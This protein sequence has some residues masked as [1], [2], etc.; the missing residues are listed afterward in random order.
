MPP[1]LSLDDLHAR[2]VN[3]RADQLARLEREGRF[4][5]RVRLSAYRHVWLES[6]IAD[7]LAARVAEREAVPA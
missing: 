3:L 2:G 1:L 5:K 6:E 7:W 4:P